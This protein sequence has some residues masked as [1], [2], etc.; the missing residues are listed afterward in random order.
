MATTISAT[1]SELQKPVN[2]VFS[3]LFLR[4]AQQN[5][6]Y[7]VGTMPGQ[8]NRRRG[9]STI[10][11]RRV[12]QLTPTTS[13]LSELTTTA[14]YMQGRSSVTASTTEVS[15]TVSKYGQFY[16]TN[17]EVDLYLP[18]GHTAELVATLGESAGRSLNQLQRNIA[19]DNSTLRYGGNVASDGAVT[20]AVVLNDLKRVINELLVNSART[21]APMTTGSQNIGTAPV[22]PAFWAINH[23]NV[24]EDVCG[25]SGFKSV[26]TYAGQ[27]ATIQGEYG[28]IQRA[29]KAIRFIQTEDASIDSGSGASGAASAGLKGTSDNVDVYT[30]V[31][32]GRDAFGSVGLG[33]RHTDGVYRAG[34][35]PGMWDLIFHDRGSGGTSDPYNEVATLAWKGFHAGAVLNSNWSRG[36]RVGATDLTA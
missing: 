18:N 9:T 21:F 15:A 34:D 16:I 8:I 22:L 11:W 33:R 2:T 3:Q 23:P 17:E 27:T 32:Y 4:R 14:S 24:S 36:I 28:L 25:I 6:P 26:E 29:G 1:D 20:A 19:E 30:I 10:T 12:D 13:A 31:V 35:D 7:F 5:C